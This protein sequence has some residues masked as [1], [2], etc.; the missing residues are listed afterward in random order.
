[1]ELL[2]READAACKGELTFQ[3][4]WEI[5]TRWW[6]QRFVIFTFT[7]GNDPISLIFYSTR[8]KPSTRRG[9]SGANLQW[10]NPSS[11]LLTCFFQSHHLHQISWFIELP[12]CLSQNRRCQWPPRL[13][14]PPSLSALGPGHATIPG[15]L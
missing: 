6:F 13:K 8:L 12:C 9:K 7:W 5:K 1:M 14:Q 10:A 4:G 15:L 3:V 2:V 11:C